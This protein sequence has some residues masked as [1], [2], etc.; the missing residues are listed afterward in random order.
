MGSTGVAGHSAFE[1]P[2][3]RLFFFSNPLQKKP[4]GGIQRPNP[5]TKQQNRP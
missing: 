2:S 5:A 1:R 4:P 3:L